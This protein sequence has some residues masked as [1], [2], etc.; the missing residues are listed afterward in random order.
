VTAYGRHTIAPVPPPFLLMPQP[1]T[2]TSTALQ[3]GAEAL[4]ANPLRT[5]LS[6]L[7]VIVGVA[8][9]VAVLSLGDGMQQAARSQLQTL[10]DVQTVSVVPRTEIQVDG[11]WEPVRNY[12]VFTPDD[13][14]DAQAQTGAIGVSLFTRASMVI[15]VPQTA[16]RRTAQVSAVLPRADE[17]HRL[18]L[19]YGR[20]L[21]D[22]E[23]QRGAAVVVLNDVLARQLADGRDI[24]TMIDASVRVHGTDMTVIGVLAPVTGDKSHTAFIPFAAARRVFPQ[25]EQPRPA[26]MLL[27]AG[28]VESTEQLR[29]RTVDWAARRYTKPLDRLDIFTQKKRVEQAEQGILIFKLFMASLTGISLLVGG[30]GIMNVMLASVSERTR[31]IGIRK[32]IGARKRD[33]LWQFLAES[34]AISGAGSAVGVV[35]GLA[36]AFGVTALIRLRANA[37]FFQAGVSV[38]TI[39]TA[40]L[41]AL[42]VGLVFGTYPALRASRMSPIDAIRH[43]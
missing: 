26:T 27:R 32:A 18:T 31:E 38:S 20:F 43:E 12:P 9:L 19:A 15:A 1:L 23:A 33:V 41:S 22:A 25:A 37:P 29:S 4:S 13:A 14:I 6:T 5:L 34:V 42:I 35:L 16:K 10:T 21:T 24:A 36:G 2:A 3:I 7:G 11:E 40:V 30:I 8:S 39:M 28:T 17:F